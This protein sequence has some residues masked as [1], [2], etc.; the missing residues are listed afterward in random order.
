MTYNVVE[1]YVFLLLPFLLSKDIL[2]EYNKQ[3]QTASIEIP[4]NY[5]DLIALDYLAI[6]NLLVDSNPQ[7][8]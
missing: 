3:Q 8:N 4:R 6:R 5:T 2:R 1:S 7:A